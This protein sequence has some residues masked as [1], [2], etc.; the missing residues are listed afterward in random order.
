MTTKAP[1]KHTV[2]VFCK[3]HSW[4]DGETRYRRAE[5]VCE[6]GPTNG[7]CDTEK[8]CRVLA[9]TDL[10]IA[11][12]CHGEYPLNWACNNKKTTTKEGE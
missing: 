11:E 3:K 2:F 8:P 5:F 1:R 4:L 6:G 10:F 7:P 9:G 12:V